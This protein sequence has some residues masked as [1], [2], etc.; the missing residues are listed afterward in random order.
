MGNFE[1][2]YFKENDVAE[3]VKELN[4]EQKATNHETWTHI[5]QVRI[6]LTKCIDE[7]NQ[8]ALGHDQ[9]KLDFPEVET[10]TEFTPKLKDAEYGSDEYK[11]FLKGM[12]PAL[13][14]HYANN[15][16]HPEHHENGM[17][18]MDLF[19]IFELLCDWKAATMRTKGGDMEKSFEI[20]KKRFNMSDQLIN[21]LRNTVN[22]I[23]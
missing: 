4:V 17:D 6:F 23:G 1:N 16:H 13:D 15:S 3:E 14:H 7:L 18:G 5:H 11:E 22:N 2:K 9:T 12:K 10:F 20:N 21:I 8:R 19:D